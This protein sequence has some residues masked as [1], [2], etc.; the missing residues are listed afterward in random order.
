MKKILFILAAVITGIAAVAFSF[1]A[2]EEIK[3]LDP[4][5]YVYIGDNSLSQQ[6]DP[7]WYVKDESPDPCTGDEERICLLQAP[8]NGTHPDFSNGNPVDDPGDF[9]NTIVYKPFQ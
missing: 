7:M 6:R 8:D 3:S 4:V 5:T 1:P 9:N 2:K